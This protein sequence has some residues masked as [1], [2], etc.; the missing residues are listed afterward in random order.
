MD[1]TLLEQFKSKQALSGE[2]YIKDLLAVPAQDFKYSCD[3]ILGTSLAY[4]G[5]TVTDSGALNLGSWVADRFNA[6]YLNSINSNR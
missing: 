3:E 2:S 4:R 5:E 1:Y 6:L